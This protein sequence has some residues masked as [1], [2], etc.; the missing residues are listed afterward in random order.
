MCQK[1]YLALHETY[2]NVGADTVM[3][4]GLIYGCPMP[5]FKGIKEA[6]RLKDITQ[7]V[8]YSQTYAI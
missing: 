2:K 3:P 7:S 6:S 5:I 4:L 8:P 1:H